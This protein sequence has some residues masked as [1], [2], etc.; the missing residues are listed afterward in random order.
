M[1]ISVVSEA[2]EVRASTRMVTLLAGLAS[3]QTLM[4]TL[5][6][7]LEWLVQLALVLDPMRTLW[8]SSELWLVLVLVPPQ[9][10]RDQA[11]EPVV[12]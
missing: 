4:R 3:P 2:L 5:Q 10:S 8:L 7:A 12:S 9:R 6:L 11:Q 1:T